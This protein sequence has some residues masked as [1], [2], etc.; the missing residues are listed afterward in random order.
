M[1]RA[2]SPGPA[3]ASS[4]TGSARSLVFLPRGRLLGSGATSP[5]TS[6]PDPGWGRQLR[7]RGERAMGAFRV[8]RV[9]PGPRKPRSSRTPSGRSRGSTP[10]A[11]GSSARLSPSTGCSAA[12]GTE[13]PPPR[14][15]QRKPAA[16]GARGAGPAGLPGG[17]PGP[18]GPAPCP[19][20]RGEF[21]FGRGRTALRLPPRSRRRVPGPR[22][23]ACRA[24]R[25]P[26]AGSPG[27]ASGHHVGEKFPSP[28]AGPL[29]LPQRGRGPPS[30]T[31]A[32][33]RRPRP[34]PPPGKPLAG[35]LSEVPR[36]RPHRS[37][38]HTPGASRAG[39]PASLAALARG[40]EGQV[41]RGGCGGAEGAGDRGPH[42]PPRQPAGPSPRPPRPR[43]P[44]PRGRSSP[45]ASGPSTRPRPRAP[46]PG[47]PHSPPPPVRRPG[48][49]SAHALGSRARPAPSLL[50]ST[51]S[52]TGEGAG[53]EGARRA[54]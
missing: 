12:T 33:L 48:R 1:Y 16:A 25:S 23:K 5:S 27:H 35:A 43:A 50:L 17:G 42:A 13:G 24:Q 52:T 14:P 38:T 21:K 8:T 40:V 9:G 19:R 10:A 34:R 3:P 11:A 44:S 46:A 29:R 15:P 49:P 28:A 37:G 41:S 45:H 6:A 32:P 2:S 39:C 53:A 4:F 47:V 20:P 30:G 26:G 31:R 36:R 22:G 7:G 54:T 18:C 51:H